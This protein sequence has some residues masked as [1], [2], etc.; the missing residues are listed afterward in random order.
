MNNESTLTCGVAILLLGLIGDLSQAQMIKT[1]LAQLVKQSQVI[2]L[3]QVHD[4]SGQSADTAVT[5]P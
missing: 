5:S 2:F 3:G 4:G 1:T